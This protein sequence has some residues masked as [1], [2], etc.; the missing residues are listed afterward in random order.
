MLASPT[1]STALGGLLLAAAVI[2][3]LLI[4]CGDDPA[5]APTGPGAIEGPYA[6]VLGTKSTV[7]TL[8]PSKA[9][10]ICSL[11]PALKEL[12]F[13][14][15]PEA[16]ED[17]GKH[18][19]FVLK[20]YTGPGDYQIEYSPSQEHEVEV[21]FP[22]EPAAAKSYRYIYF[23]HLRLDL[24]ATYRSHCDFS[25]AVEELPD[26]TRLSGTLSCGS[27]WA[28]FDTLDYVSQP[29]NGFADLVARF[30]CEQAT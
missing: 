18:L 27:L 14:A 3:S 17:A 12:A 22:A 21:S 16:P 11:K 23:Q 26:R 19:R 2:V 29:L 30:E 28:D 13:E 20:G 7:I 24:N 4:G 1:R 9:R 8:D 5:S 15:F 25:I 10:V 6:L